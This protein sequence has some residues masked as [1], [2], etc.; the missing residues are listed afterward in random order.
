VSNV[1][2]S[3]IFLEIADLLDLQGESRFRVEAYRRAARTIESL[4]EDLAR[5]AERGGLGTIPGVGSALEAKIREYLTTGK[6]EYLARLRSEVP[7]GLLELMRLPGVGPKTARRLWL[8][9]QVEGPQ[10]LAQ[11]IETGVVQRLPGFKERKIEQLRQGL[12]ALGTTA[13]GAGR[14]PVLEAWE[15]AQTIREQLRATVPVGE[16]RVAG[17]LR[18]CRETVGDLD[19][20]ATSGEP[21]RV[22]R[23]FAHLPG[24]LEVR[25]LGDTKS[26]VVRAP[27]IQVDLRVVPPESFGAALQYFTGSKD[28]NVHLRT[29]ARDKGLKVNEYG[30]F[31]GE[32]RIAGASE[33]EVYAALG[34][35]EIPPEI[36]ENQGEIEQAAAGR[37]PALV[38]V[39]SAGGDVHVHLSAVPSS[40]ELEA[41]SAAAATVGVPALALVVQDG[42]GGKERFSELLRAISRRGRPAGAAPLLPGWERDAASQEPP[43]EGARLL[44]LRPGPRD[45]PSGPLANPGKL[46]AVLVHLDAR[47]AG[48]ASADGDAW[49]AWAT[50]NRVAVEMGPRP[51]QSGI[52]SGAAKLLA[53]RG[54]LLAASADAASPAE[55]RRIA[56]SVGLLRRAGLEARHLLAWSAARPGAP[57][58]KDPGRPRRGSAASR[59][60]RS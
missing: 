20:L 4:G 59:P 44:L 50:R 32:E 18:R 46:P 36:R 19:L 13:S 51:E 2:M 38:T 10:E 30:V 35:P 8:E 45:P 29:I 54:T 16:L 5:F 22:L 17:S 25:G 27:G 14:R 58:S 21:A 9:A 43:P 11:A 24:V 47:P 28:H 39:A 57:L 55:L 48:G 23:E 15:L 3:R 40:G 12:A 1:E 34:L 33:A 42:T 7:P 53:E 37:L 41:W 31:R 52:D 49:L 56:V 6:L 26:T 60:K